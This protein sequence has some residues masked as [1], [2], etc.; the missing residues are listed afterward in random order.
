MEESFQLKEYGKLSLFEQAQMV[1]EERS[2]WL[3]R[4]EK[5][6]EDRKKAEEGAASGVSRPSIPSVP[7]VSMPSVSV[8][9]I[10]VPRR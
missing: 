1:A 8:P 5:E 10:S 7:G 9:S 4:I 2:W 6:Y 3:K